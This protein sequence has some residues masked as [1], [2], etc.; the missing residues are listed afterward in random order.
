MSRN[1]ALSFG[2]QAHKRVRRVRRLEKNGGAKLLPVTIFHNKRADVQYPERLDLRGLYR[3]IRDR[4]AARAKANCYWLKL[5]EFG[6][7][8][9]PKGSLRHDGNVQSVSGIEFD[10]DLGKRSFEEAVDAIKAAELAAIV[11]TSPG[12]TEGYPK[13]RVLVLFSRTYSGTTDELRKLRTRFLARLNGVLWGGASPESFALSQSYY[14]G[15]VRGVEFRIELVE[16]DCIDERDDL[17]ATAVS[18]SAAAQLRAEPS[19]SDIW[20]RDK[21]NLS[22]AFSEIR[23]GEAFHDNTMRAAAHLVAGGAS[24]RTATGVLRAVMEQSEQ[25]NNERWQKRYDDIP[26]LVQSAIRK[27]GRGGQEIGSFR[28]LSAISFDDFMGMDIPPRKSLL[29]PVLREQGLMLVHS[30]RGTGKTFLSVGIAVALTSGGT[31]LG[32]SAPEAVSVL[33]VDGEMPA[34]A[35]KQRLRQA[36]KTG[37]KRVVA[38]L[39]IVTPDLNR[40]ARMPD[41]ATPEGQAALDALVGDA[42]VIILDN[43]SCL[44]TGVENDAESWQPLQTWALRHRAQGRSIIFFHHSGKGGQQRGTSRREDVLDIV[45]GLRRPSDYSPT[46][47]A[48]FEVHIEKGR[49]IHGNAAGGF[50][51]W[52]KESAPGLYRWECR[53]LEEDHG[54]RIRE[55]TKE[56]KKPSEIASDLDIHRSTV[57]RHLKSKPNSDT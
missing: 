39:R 47:G 29:D 33:L 44:M 22:T 40:E 55:L 51:A 9:S 34:D 5:A 49:G 15:R 52:L 57:Y 8:P 4:P 21:F 50:E 16:G 31:F 25:R 46:Q 42:R 6:E 30:F 28:P 35:L 26:R 38:P 53:E 20:S 12:Y 13:W 18:P 17:D 19:E 41:L 2:R 11:Y 43:L 14:Y 23:T 54:V 56:G 27:Y 45:I 48:R 10:Y 3:E 37:G 36:K 7:V 32:W 1:T 24:E